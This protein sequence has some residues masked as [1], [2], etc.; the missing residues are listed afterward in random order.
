MLLFLPFLTDISF[1][2]YY[3]NMI[4]I[5]DKI[6]HHCKRTGV[7][8]V[9]E[10]QKIRC[11]IVE[12]I[13]LSFF[14]HKNHYFRYFILTWLID[15]AIRRRSDGPTGKDTWLTDGRNLL[16]NCPIPTNN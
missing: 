10:M 6:P 2:H 4:L 9:Q 15:G 5:I 7:M 16:L 14:D 1:L 3:K 13:I 11:I 8:V 12:Y